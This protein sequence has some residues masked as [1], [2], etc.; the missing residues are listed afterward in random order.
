MEDPPAVGTPPSDSPL[1]HKKAALRLPEPSHPHSCP[2]L[3]PAAM[4]HPAPIFPAANAGIASSPTSPSPSPRSSPQPAVSLFSPPADPASDVDEIDSPA[5]DAMEVE[6]PAAVLVVPGPGSPTPAAL[7]APRQ[8]EDTTVLPSSSMVVDPPRSPVP[9][10]PSAEDLFLRRQAD[11][12][13]REWRV[14][15]KSALSDHPDFA[16]PSFANSFPALWNR[17]LAAFPLPQDAQEAEW[18][19]KVLNATLP[20]LLRH[21][22]ARAEV[23]KMDSVA[24]NLLNHIERSERDV[25]DTMAAATGYRESYRTLEQ[26]VRDRTRN[27]D[28]VTDAVDA[29]EALAR[30]DAKARGLKGSAVFK[31]VG[32]CVAEHEAKTEA[33]TKDLASLGEDLADLSSKIANITDDLA[34]AKQVRDDFRLELY[35]TRYPLPAPPPS[36]PSTIVWSP[37]HTTALDTVPS[38]VFD[39]E[40]GPKTKGKGKAKAAPMSAPESPLPRSPSPAAGPSKRPAPT[41][42]DESEPIAIRRPERSKPAPEALFLPPL[43]DSDVVIVEAEDSVPAAGSSKPT[44]RSQTAE[45]G[46]RPLGVVLKVPAAKTSNLPFAKDMVSTM[47]FYACT[48]CL[49]LGLTCKRAPDCK[50]CRGCQNGKVGCEE[51]TSGR[52]FF[53]APKTR[54]VLDTEGLTTIAGQASTTVISRPF[55][56]PPVLVPGHPA[57]TAAAF[58][59]Q[60]EYHLSLGF[61]QLRGFRGP[62]HLAGLPVTLPGDP[63]HRLHS[64]LDRL[65]S[66]QGRDWLHSID[67]SEERR[68]DGD[69][70]S[71]GAEAAEEA[72]DAGARVD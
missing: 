61:A 65:E 51:G 44:T 47:P 49:R 2:T 62:L 23:R 22:G 59:E 55:L 17:G 56:L 40:E 5:P 68:G 43:S 26:Q 28:Q 34:A 27:L 52:C 20:F 25:Q 41:S 53:D 39:Q 18:R 58:H 60:A 30:E 70:D 11:L 31:F 3:Q 4:S 32:D 54:R 14:E 69:A 35:E 38:T 50:A 57:N 1:G 6:S 48:R 21:S 8:A 15:V 66:E 46:K 12:A 42:G 29:V 37:G 24:G 45:K 9:P 36:A 19:T 64:Y 67:R 72:D 7:V 33:R 71:S 10:I 63:G 13:H 16:S